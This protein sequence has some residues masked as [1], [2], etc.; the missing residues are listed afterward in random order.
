MADL[1]EDYAKLTAAQTNRTLHLAR[2][3]VLKEEAERVRRELATSEDAVAILS[4][5][6]EAMRRQLREMIL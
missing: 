6:I 2:I 1:T 4:V 3:A 5:R